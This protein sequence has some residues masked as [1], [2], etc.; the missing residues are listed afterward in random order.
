MGKLLNLYYPVEDEGFCRKTLH[1]LEVKDMKGVAIFN[2][3]VFTQID[4]IFSIEKNE[5][6]S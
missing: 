1:I 6:W 5:I 3:R 2:S 4:K